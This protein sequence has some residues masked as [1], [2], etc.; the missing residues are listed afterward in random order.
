LSGARRTA[1]PH[2][3]RWVAD[4]RPSKLAVEAR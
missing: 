1:D 3:C 4:G 2:M